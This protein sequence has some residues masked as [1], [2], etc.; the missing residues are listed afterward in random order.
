VAGLLFLVGT[1]GSILG[2]ALNLSRH[3]ITDSQRL[4]GTTLWLATLGLIMNGM[5]SVVFN[6]ITL[7]WLYFWLAGAVVTNSQRI[8]GVERVP[9]ALELTPVG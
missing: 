7:A 6:S 9:G 3:G 8:R 5:T 1:L 2:H 4:M